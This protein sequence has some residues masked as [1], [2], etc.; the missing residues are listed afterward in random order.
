M[1]HAMGGRSY[2]AEGS[3]IDRERA[4]RT[5]ERAVEW[6]GAIVQR[7]AASMQTPEQ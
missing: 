6:A 5:A 3:P 1:A 7:V 2:D 4:V